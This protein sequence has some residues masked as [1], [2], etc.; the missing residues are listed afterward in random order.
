[1]V[2]GGWYTERTEYLNPSEN[3]YTSTVASI[4]LSGNATQNGLLYKDRILT[5]SKDVIETSLEP[6]GESRILLQEKQSRCLSGVHRFGDNVYIVGG[7]ESKMEKYDV[8]K[9]EMKTLP[10]LPYKVSG[11]SMATVAYKDNIIIIGGS[12]GKH[13]LNDVAMFN[14]T[15]HEY[16]KFSS[17]LEKRSFC[18]AV[19]MGD[20]IVVMGGSNNGPLMVPTSLNTA[21]Y[22]V[23][24]EAAWQKLPAMNLA[25]CCATSCVYV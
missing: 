11:G 19:I 15:T 7:Q 17:M 6:S 4:S 10:S 2:C 22:Y 14:V 16:K 5:F 12:D 8:A 13:S 25:R 23:I 21:E 24:G 1:M 9:N 3:G 20:V 18:T